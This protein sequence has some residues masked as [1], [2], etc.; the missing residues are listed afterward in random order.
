MTLSLHQGD[1]GVRGVQKEPGEVPKPRNGQEP[2]GINPSDIIEHVK[3]VFLTITVSA[4]LAPSR[5]L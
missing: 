2:V 3:V 4:V 1:K 5:L